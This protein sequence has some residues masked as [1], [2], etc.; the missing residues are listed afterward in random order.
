MWCST[1]TFMYPFFDVIEVFGNGKSIL[2]VKIFNNENVLY[3][4]ECH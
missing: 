2:N 3:G 4:W 1:I